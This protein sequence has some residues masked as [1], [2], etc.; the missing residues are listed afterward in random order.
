MTTNRSLLLVE[1]NEDDVFLMKRALKE[2]HVMNPLYVVVDGQ[3]AV[4]YLAGKG[5]FTDRK[6]YPLPA[7][8]FL[9]LKLPYI[10]GHDVLAWIR[11]QKEHES[12]VV[13]VLTSSNEA[14]DLS[15]CYSL[16]ANSYLVKPP[17]PEQLG[18]LAKAFKWYWLEYNQ[19]NGD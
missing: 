13:I 10:S 4:D 19:F 11:G 8:V 12:L 5:R 16:G 18:D 1:D 2:A 17:T 15:R 3:E 14:S 7:V 9:D 6:R